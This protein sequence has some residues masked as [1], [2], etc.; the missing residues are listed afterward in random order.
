MLLAAMNQDSP[1]P[2]DKH[3]YLSG[4]YF[5][6]EDFQRDLTYELQGGEK[7]KLLD[8]AIL[9]IFSFTKKLKRREESET[10]YNR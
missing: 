10:G 3:F 2:K 4:L 7:F 1:Y 9:P 5:H 6:G 8:T